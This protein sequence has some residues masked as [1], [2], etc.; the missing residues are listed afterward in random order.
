M[1]RV[2]ERVRLGGHD[3]PEEVVRRR[4]ASGVRNLL[5]L[6]PGA[7]DSWQV[8]D[9]SSLERPRLIASGERDGATSIIDARAWNSLLAQEGR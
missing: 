8:F 6:Y 7:V 4:Y 2:A 9:N 1:R 3:V 5:R